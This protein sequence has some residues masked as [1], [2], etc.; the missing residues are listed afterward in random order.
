MFNISKYN[1]LGNEEYWLGW[2]AERGGAYVTIVLRPRQNT[3]SNIYM[4]MLTNL[5]IIFWY[6]INTNFFLTISKLL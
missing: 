3:C 2:G 5:L 4:N 1:D 6:K